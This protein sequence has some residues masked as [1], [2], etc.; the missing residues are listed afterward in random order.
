MVRKA[1]ILDD[2]LEN[3]YRS[4]PDLALAFGV[5]ASTIRRHLARLEKLNLVQRTHGGALPIRH[6]DTPFAVKQSLHTS[7]KVAIG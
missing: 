2:L 5:D 6:A 3:G 1:D 7:E 4:V